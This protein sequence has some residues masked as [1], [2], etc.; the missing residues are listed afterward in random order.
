[1][2]TGLWQSVPTWNLIAWW[3]HI[4]RENGDFQVETCVIREA[5]TWWLFHLK[6]NATNLLLPCF[7]SHLSVY[8]VAA[9]TNIFQMFV[10]HVIN[11]FPP[12]LLEATGPNCTLKFYLNSRLLQTTADRVI[13]WT[14]RDEKMQIMHENVAVIA[15]VKGWSKSCYIMS[16]CSIGG[17]CI[18][19]LWS[20]SQI[21]HDLWC[22]STYNDAK[23]KLLF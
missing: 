5:I 9:E 16:I 17:I 19:E 3:S 13:E 4:Y 11:V 15:A 6:I 8:L 22:S 21:F 12:P 14:H 1:M 10:D 7:D 2:I 23:E 20:L 18:L